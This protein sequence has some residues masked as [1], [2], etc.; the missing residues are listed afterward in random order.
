MDA[1]NSSDPEGLSSS[2]WASLLQSA[3]PTSN[4]PYYVIGLDFGTSNSCI[5]V[6]RRDKNRVKIV[7]NTKGTRSPL[8]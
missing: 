2:I 7:K 5:S 6:W 8:I 3:L 1:Q 4:E